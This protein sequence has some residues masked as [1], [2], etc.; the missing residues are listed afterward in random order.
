MPN[1]VNKKKKISCYIPDLGLQL[2]VLAC[3][4]CQAS[5]LNDLISS[6]G[7]LAKPALDVPCGQAQAPPA[8]RKKW[9]YVV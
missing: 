3:L 7:K 8:A 4:Q 5:D 1:M 9:G 2:C 6:K